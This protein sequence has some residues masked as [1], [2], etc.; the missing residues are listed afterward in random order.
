M[1][2]EMAFP[3]LIT[4]FFFAGAF[5]L[6]GRHLKGMQAQRDLP[7]RDAWLAS[8]GVAGECCGHCGSSQFD[9]RGLDDKDDDKRV[10]SCA[11]CKALLYRYQ[12]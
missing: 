2:I 11:Q 5:V 7:S 3:L 9:D 10:V 6:V 1:A 12:R 8:R 4:L